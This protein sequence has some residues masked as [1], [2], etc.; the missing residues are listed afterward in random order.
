M[1]PRYILLLSYCFTSTVFAESVYPINPQQYGMHKPFGPPKPINPKT[2]LTARPD[3]QFDL[4]DR[5]SYPNAVHSINARMDKP[6][7]FTIGQYGNSTYT[8]ALWR[9]REANYYLLGN[10]HYTQ[11]KHYKDGDNNQV[12]YGFKRKGATLV[13]GVLPNTHTEHRITL[14]YDEIDDDKQPQHQM[15]PI[16]TR[17]IIGKYNGRF[18]AQDNSNTVHVELSA[19][20]IQR[21][22]NNF[23]V[24]TNPAGTPRVIMDVERK[25]YAADLHYNYAW[26]EQ[27]HST[28]GLGFKYDTQ[29]AKRFV[30]TPVKLVQNG[31]RFPNVQVQTTSLYA[32]HAWKPNTQNTIKAAL[33]YDWQTA[34]AR[35]AT[36]PL[37]IP[38]LPTPQRLWQM[39][40]GK[41]LTGKIKNKGMSGKLYYAYQP[42]AQQKFYGEFA[43]LYRMPSNP[44]RF[45]VLPAPA[46]SGKGWASNPWIKPERENRITLGM[47]LNGSGWGGYQNTKQD[48]YA[49]AWQLSGSVFYADIND[50]I[51][52][53][54]YRGKVPALRG[55]IIS[56]N[57]NAKLAGADLSYR[58]NWT[59][60]LSTA[61]GMSYRYGKNT[62]DNRP[63]YQIAPFAANLGVD[64]KGYFN[65]GS[66][67][68]GS[69]LH[70][71]HQQN[72]RDDNP[73]TGLGIDN[74]IKGF[75]TVDVYA[76]VEWSNNVGISVGV[77]N[78]FDRSYAK[79]IT[80][81]HVESV[82]PRVI[83]APGRTF[84]LRLNA[85]F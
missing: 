15:D 25:K 18:G 42:T 39:Y 24:R 16:N 56:R 14:V 27:H 54:R 19:A 5:A 62:T 4:Q 60:N 71:Q 3:N 52:L 29:D 53:D 21:D 69:R 31:Y 85:A 44:E 43:S 35:A 84:W 48:A 10:I 7:H 79:Y 73:L 51:T 75:T 28:I 74:N 68:V 47:Q 65:G 49:S 50:F 30:K 77:D 45:A 8:G 2:V 6:F 11:A 59:P 20:D 36:S 61:L 22:A 76:G 1:K 82:A 72:R 17:R 57:V 37:G 32:A 55:N 34:Q 78:V 38:M 9:Q 12:N 80:H 81:D 66:Y 46:G 41:K 70:Y 64:W 40:Y 63:L 26:N 67:S 83:N 13:A 33:N 23:D 58:Q